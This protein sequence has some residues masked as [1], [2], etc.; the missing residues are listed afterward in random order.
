[1]LGL[2]SERPSDGAP[3]MR[4]DL[5]GEIRLASMPLFQRQRSDRFLLVQLHDHLPVAFRFGYGPSIGRGFLCAVSFLLELRRFGRA[6]LV[7]LADG[8]KTG[9]FLL[10]RLRDAR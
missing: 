7:G 6:P 5:S 8:A 9:F 10:P 2:L 1:M 4:S 3:G